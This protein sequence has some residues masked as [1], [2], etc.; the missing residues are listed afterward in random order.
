MPRRRPSRNLCFHIAADTVHHQ[1]AA[2]G[3][4]RGEMFGIFRSPSKLLGPKNKS[5]NVIQQ[6]FDRFGTNVTFGMILFTGVGKLG[7]R[8]SPTAGRA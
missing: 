7:E 4:R 1:Y 5:G 3:N 8:P 2:R 6:A